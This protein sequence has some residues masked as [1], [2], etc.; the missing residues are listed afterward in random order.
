MWTECR[1]TWSAAGTVRD[2]CFATHKLESESSTYPIHTSDGTFQSFSITGLWI[3]RAVHVFEHLQ[4]LA[5][6][7]ILFVAI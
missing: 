2:R 1:A 7:C 6:S 4:D 5:F 3:A